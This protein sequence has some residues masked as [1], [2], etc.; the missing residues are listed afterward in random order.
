MEH[1]REA[2]ER[3]KE[4][5]P[6]GVP[7]TGTPL[8]PLL[9]DS[10]GAHVDIEELRLN[11]VQLED[12]RIIAHDV[13][14]PRSKPIDMLRTQVL[15]SMNL[16]SW[17]LLGVTSPTAS[18]GK[19]VI[20]INLALSIARQSERS[21]LLV[22]LDFQ[23]PQV[24]KYLGFKRDV[25][26]LGVLEGR[27]KLSGAVKKTR[28]Y[29]QQLFVLPCEA[30]TPRS[31]EFMSSRAMTTVLQ[32]IKRDFRACTVIFDLPPMLPSDDVLSILPNIDCVMLVAAAET[33]TIPEIKECTKFLEAVPVVRVVLNKASDKVA[34]YYGRYP[35]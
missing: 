29:N 6:P 21:V 16:N 34:A 23:K 11:A 35:E 2:I 31:S 3:A 17:Q 4:T 18:C 7:G 10:N 24:A 30:S 15:Q 9:H 5:A 28:I 27:T 14:D 1:I 12:N 32:D 22:D 26:I 19:S 33:S 25:G 8:Q 13:A 20:S